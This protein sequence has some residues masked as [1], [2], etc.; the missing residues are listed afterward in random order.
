[1]LRQHH[2]TAS[3]LIA[4]QVLIFTLSAGSAH[5]DT[6]AQNLGRAA[7]AASFGELEI[8]PQDGTPYSRQARDQY[9]CDI[10][11]AKQTAFDP[12]LPDGGV[13][14]DVAPARQADYLRAE[15]ACLQARGYT[16]TIVQEVP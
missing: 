3:A 2:R 15:A 12:T 9:Q 1:M 10:A 6:A 4:L 13:P 16:V 7:R 11:A 5:A 8:H 14:A